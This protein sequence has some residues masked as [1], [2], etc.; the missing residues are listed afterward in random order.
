MPESRVASRSGEELP[1]LCYGLLQTADFFSESYYCFRLMLTFFW[2]LPSDDWLPYFNTNFFHDT[3]SID[4]QTI[5]PCHY[6]GSTPCVRYHSPHLYIFCSVVLVC[7]IN[8]SIFR[9]LP[10]KPKQILECNIVSSSWTIDFLLLKLNTFYCDEIFDEQLFKTE[11]Q[12]YLEN[13][14]HEKK[15]TTINN[16]GAH[17][18]QREFL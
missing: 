7:L 5:T 9:R 18:S 6:V 10:S 17:V 1:G 4:L 8:P 12:N 16:I 11:I 2:W 15:V 14:P 3:D 13:I